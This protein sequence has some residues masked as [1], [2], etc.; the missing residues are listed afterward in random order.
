MTHVTNRP[1]NSFV[2]EHPAISVL[3]PLYN[4]Q[5][6]VRRA[7]ASVLA[8]SVSDYELIVVDDGSTDDG[9]RM[10]ASISDPKLR[11]VHQANAGVSAARNRGVSE[12]RAEVVAFLDA[13]DEWLPDLLETIVRLVS[14]FPECRVYATGYAYAHAG[15][16]AR[17][18]ILRGLPRGFREGILDDYFRVAAH[19]DPPLWS[20][21][22]AVQKAAL[23]MVGGFPVGI[24]SGE[25][26]LTWARLACSYRVAYS[27]QPRALYWIPSDLSARRERTPAEPDLVA[28]GLAG[29]LNK[30]PPEERVA[31]E[32]YCSHWKRMRG[33][34]CLKQGKRQK[35]LVEFNAACR[36]SGASGRLR[37]M[38]TLAQL[39]AGDTAFR[40]L[41]HLR[42]CLR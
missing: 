41:L 32:H 10:V 14:N 34:D 17:P 37:L 30:T 28:E 38:K 23:Q 31:L 12:A 2:P 13:D 21:A 6:E 22:V 20:S 9:P 11:M 25:D 15:R 19:S 40:A 4:K 16:R 33:V 35:A 5:G 27:V 29:L 26:L 1:V 36:Y 3:I 8:Q 18:A 24:A 42:A 39:P 7:I